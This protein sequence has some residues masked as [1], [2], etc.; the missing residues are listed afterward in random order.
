MANCAMMNIPPSEAR[1]LTRHDYESLIHNW[2]LAHSDG[3]E[4]PM[5]PTDDEIEDAQERMH[6]LERRGVK[7][8][9]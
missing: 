4:P 1:K 6:Q 9:H 5:P 2:S 8:L 7:V 3:S